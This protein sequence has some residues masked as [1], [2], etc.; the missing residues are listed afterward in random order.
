M[1]YNKLFD[2]VYRIEN[3]ASRDERAREKWGEDKKSE[4]GRGEGEKEKEKWR[5]QTTHC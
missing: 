3:R 4:R 2:L 5:L 1:A